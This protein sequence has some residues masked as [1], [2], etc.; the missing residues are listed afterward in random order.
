MSKPIFEDLFKFSGRRNRKSYILLMLAQVAGLIGLA[1]L[2]MIGVAL[3]DS[4]APLG[5]LVM[6]AVIAGFIAICITGWA[7]ASQRVRDFGHSGVWVLLILVPYVGWL[8]SLAICFIPST[9][10]ENKYGPSCI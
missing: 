3:L 7:S 4:F 1:M 2:S 8:V 5:Y 6:L 9:P 10:G